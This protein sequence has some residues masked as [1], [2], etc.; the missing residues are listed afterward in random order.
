MTTN[1][2]IFFFSQKKVKLK[3]K[4]DIYRINTST[5]NQLNNHITLTKLN[6]ITKE[7]ILTI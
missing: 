6:K 4:K 3:I 5:P 7:T 1:I 2:Y